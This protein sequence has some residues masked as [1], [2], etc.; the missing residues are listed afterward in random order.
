MT[1]VIAEKVARLL[2]AMI[3]QR[4]DLHKHP[5]PGWTEFRTSAIISKRLS[6]LG[7]KLTRGKDAVV[8]DSMM[9]APSDAALKQEQERAIRQGADPELV[10][11]M[12]GGLTGLW[13]DMEFKGGKGPKF[14]LRFDM[15]SNDV[16][17][18][19]DPEH[20]PNKEGFA[21]VNHG[22][23][24]ACG[25]DGHV[26]I[27]LA[28]AE[29]LADMKDELKGSVRLI[30]QPAEE[31]VRGAGPM[32][33]AGCVKNVDI[34]V[35]THISFQADKT[36]MIICGTRGFLATTKWDVDFTGKSAHAGAAPHEG[37]N[38]LLAACAATT[39]M[40]AIARHGDG[41][42]RITVGRLEGGQGRNIIPAHAHLAMETRGLTSELDDYMT[43]ECRRIIEAA[44]LMW[45]CS[46]NIK[47]MGGT[48]SGEPTPDMVEQAMKVATS[49]PAF[50]E[51]VGIKDF[52]AS[53]DYSHM[54]SAV[55][56]NGG[57]GIY[58]QVGSTRT[59]GHHN[60]HFDFEE[61]DMV[62][63]AEFLVKLV[64]SYLG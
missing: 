26:S 9:G 22:A 47:V 61:N 48:K 34:I 6:E 31:G 58:V 55:Q 33:D 59:A 41:I 42:T 23:M 7:Y 60:D 27:G 2:P 35:G 28:V 56:A 51:V 29:L 4:R 64:R 50:T 49:M 17:E 13:A 63:A 20:R 57:K 44:A 39:N 53:E 54:M 62:V 25:H 36:G 15:D 12:E 40:H 32:V 30:F 46:Y 11:D 24:H 1:D 14:A 10:R 5:E 19:E 18:T 3:V 8:K 16:I 43:G 21:S 37:K 52:G 45:D 38:A